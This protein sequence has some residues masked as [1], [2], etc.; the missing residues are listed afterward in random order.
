M[1]AP[2]VTA[3]PSTVNLAPGGF[4]DVVITG[5]DPDTATGTATFVVTDGEGNSTPV[6]VIIDIA[7]PL[8]FDPVALVVDVSATVTQQST[9]TTTATYRIQV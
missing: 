1:A 8:T 7:D 6:V 3:A 5:V 4:V 9:T 2:L